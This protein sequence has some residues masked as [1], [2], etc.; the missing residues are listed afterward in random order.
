MKILKVL[1]LG[2]SLSILFIVYRNLF[3]WIRNNYSEFIPSIG[4]LRI[5]QNNSSQT[6]T[7]NDYQYFTKLQVYY[8]DNCNTKPKFQYNYANDIK[9]QQTN[10]NVI[11]QKDEN[12]SDNVK[13]L[14]F[15]DKNL[16]DKNTSIE[17][18][19]QRISIL[20][21]PIILLIIF[22]FVGWF[23]CC[24]CCCY[25]YCP[26]V[27]KKKEGELFSTSLKITPIFLVVFSGLSLIIPA[28]M[29]N[30]NYSSMQTSLGY[31]YCNFIKMGV[32]LYK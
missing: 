6:Q 13:N 29:A 24:S 23:V 10:Q 27:C 31:L 15:E 1:I 32:L 17:N 7:S 14:L 5:L 25:E 18:I 26:I 28:V 30:K 16:F 19:I 20:L 11:F 2:F 22:S 9:V 8:K 3:D 12:L 21:L 4:E